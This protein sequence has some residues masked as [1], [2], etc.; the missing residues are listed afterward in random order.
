M[1]IPLLFLLTQVITAS[2]ATNWNVMDM[3]AKPDGSTD[4]TAVFQAALDEAGKAGG[5]TVLVP[6]GK[7]AIKGNLKIPAA[8][9]LKG[10]FSMPPTNRF[11]PA[12]DMIGTVLLAY[13]GRGSQEGDPFIR[14]AGHM[15]VLQGVIVTY[16]EWKQSDVPPVPY[17]PCVLA[18]DVEDTGV[19]D[20]CLVN[21]YEGVRFV[22]A[23]RYLVRNMFGYP[24]W[25]AFYVDQCY[26]IGKVENCHIWPF[27]V[28]YDPNDPYC[29]WINRNGV[30][31][32]FART[33][34]NYVTHTFC[35]GYG[36]G[37]KFSETKAGS[38]NGSFV[39]IGADCCTRAVLV[40]QCQ[41]PG[42]LITN[43]EFVGMWANQDSVTVEVAESS[44]GKVSMVNCSF[45]GPIDRCIWDRSP[46]AQVTADACN[47]VHWDI[48]KIGSPCIQVDAG[49][50]IVQASTF[51]S[52]DLHVKVGEKVRSAILMANQAESGFR[53]ENHAGKRTQAIGN[54]EDPLEWTEEMLGNY[55]I[56]LGRP[57]DGRFL[58][59]WFGPEPPGKKDKDTPT[60]RWS[61]A[62]SDM[63]LPILP[64]T[65]YE[66]TL[67]ADIP[68]AAVDST[69]GVYLGNERLAP[70]PTGGA[71]DVTITVPVPPMDGDRA[72]L[73]LQCKGWI[74]AQIQQG[75][76]DNRTLGIQVY[77]IHVRAKGAGEKVFHVNREK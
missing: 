40:E 59:R 29:K 57:H 19:I 44:G 74:P 54:E 21:P 8:V 67:R 10:V 73:T 63:I 70:L 51:G 4:N 24:S 45:W 1:R 42:L 6:A 69:S 35:F 38:C 60:W 50:I 12:P 5:G 14:L 15:A 77:E 7:Y 47:F 46:R 18:E 3:G 31:Y 30:A 43:G 39:G 27:G 56:Q 71:S 64:K 28:S 72:T 17:P 53:V 68:V 49:K 66:V 55:K 23:P 58:M 2:Q 22:R 9:T 16:P 61:S 25:R 32:E 11:D 52:G 75:S 13:A 41:D 34:W 65:E 37:Y 26:D 20:C 33:D 62:A 48:G 76:Q 36:V